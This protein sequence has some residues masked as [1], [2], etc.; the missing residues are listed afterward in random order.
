MAETFTGVFSTSEV[1]VKIKKGNSFVEIADMESASLTIEPNVETWYSIKGGGW[2]NALVTAKAWKL[3]MSGKRSIGDP[4]NDHLA[5][6]A[7]ANGRACNVELQ[8]EFPDG[9]T[10]EGKA[11][12]AVSNFGVDSATSVGPL[13]AEFTGQGAPT[14]TPAGST[15]T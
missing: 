13:S 3:S 12:A 2:H 9:S 5:S 4:G 14:Y 10:F 7:F 15:A 11:A 6:L 8:L 1:T